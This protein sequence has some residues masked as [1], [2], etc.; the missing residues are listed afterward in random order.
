MLNLNKHMGKKEGSS[1]EEMCQFFK[2]KQA[3][4]DS[5]A[6]FTPP[7]DLRKTLDETTYCQTN[8]IVF[9]QIWKFRWWVETSIIIQL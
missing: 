6:S 4:S 9:D 5:A 2:E 1:K 3:I 8:M 7:K